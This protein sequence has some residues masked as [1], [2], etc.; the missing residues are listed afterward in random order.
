MKKL[1]KLQKKNLSKNKV[2]KAK[3]RNKKEDYPLI[4]QNIT[5]NISE[6]TNI[7]KIKRA[8]TFNKFLESFNTLSIEEKIIEKIIVKEKKYENREQEEINI[9]TNPSFHKE[10]DEITDKIHILENTIRN[11]VPKEIEYENI[12]FKLLHTIYENYTKY[13][14]H[15][16]N[17][18]K[19]TGLSNQNKFCTSA[20]KGIKNK[21]NPNKFKFYLINEHSELCKEDI[22][23]NVEKRKKEIEEIEKI[24]KTF[25]TKID[26]EKFLNLLESYLRNNQ[27][28]NIQC[29]DFIKYG[30]L[31]YHKNKNN[32]DDF[33]KI[34][35]TFL[36][37]TYYNLLKKLYDLNLENL[38]EYSKILENGEN[39]CRTI[40]IK[41]LISKELKMIEHKAIIFFSDFD[42]KRLLVS[43]HLLIDGTFVYPHNYSQTI[44]I[45]YY[46]I[47][48]LKMIPGIFIV[49]NNKTEEGYIDCF[50]YIKYYIDRLLIKNKNQVKFKT[51]TT[52]F[53]IAL[54]KAFD[55]IFNQDKSIKHI[56]YYFHYVQNIRKYLQKE[57]FTSKYFSNLYNDI[58]KICRE[59]PF[60]NM[61]GKDLMLYI[62]KNR[63]NI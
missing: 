19:K 31:L 14:W 38:Y 28:F 36:K 16:K 58:M 44:I 37:N 10:G 18:R 4:Y 17:Y 25:D 34:N 24:Q 15:C 9:T 52:D 26:K 13:T 46:D 63:K 11:N 41:Q 23:K 45:M 1:S 32:F 2:K 59:L 30:K 56:G 51:F 43:E 33:F 48:I 57:G 22:N 29:R 62:K 50:M 12:V 47:I 5:K 27:Q 39:F 6:L 20:I 3:R 53:E 54:F 61:K 42:I 8:N 55:Y 49:I 35:D 60:K 21:E 40:I 7:K